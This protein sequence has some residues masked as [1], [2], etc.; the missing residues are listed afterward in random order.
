M[1]FAISRLQ[2][3]VSRKIYALIGLGFLGLLGVM[4]LDS[5]ELAS[6]LK[7][8]Q[9]QQPEQ[10]G[11]SGKRR[12]H[13]RA[14]IVDDAASAKP[15]PLEADGHGKRDADLQGRLGEACGIT[16]DIAA[17]DGMANFHE[18]QQRR[19]SGLTA[20]IFFLPSRSPP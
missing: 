8:V 14:D 4:F 16:I 17:V 20:S 19:A 6:S 18:G 10:S 7:I 1:S 2:M 3:T 15:Q 9:E 11:Q 12:Q 5:R 13:D